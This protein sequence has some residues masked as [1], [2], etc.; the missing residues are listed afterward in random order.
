MFIIFYK[1]KGSDAPEDCEETLKKTTPDS[2]FCS[3]GSR[4]EHW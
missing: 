3:E 2:Y 4:K 1:V